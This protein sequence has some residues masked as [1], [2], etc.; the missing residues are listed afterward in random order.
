L[1]LLPVKQKH[2]HTNEHQLY[3]NYSV[4]SSVTFLN[5]TPVHIALP[6]GVCN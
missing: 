2:M 4:T 5:S 1:V 6:M 3:E